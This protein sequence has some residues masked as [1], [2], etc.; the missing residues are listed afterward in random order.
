[1]SNNTLAICETVRGTLVTLCPDCS[2]EVSTGATA[3][4]A[5]QPLQGALRG[6]GQRQTRDTQAEEDQVRWWQKQDCVIVCCLREQW[7][8]G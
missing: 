8:N 7:I 1:M 3:A 2:W 4:Q 5:G 6:R